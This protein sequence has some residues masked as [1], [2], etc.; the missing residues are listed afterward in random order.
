MKD[1]FL[2][3]SLCLIGIGILFMTSCHKCEKFVK[4]QPVEIG[5]EGVEVDLARIA[6]A[7]PV[8]PSIKVDKV[9]VETEEASKEL[10]DLDLLQYGTCEAIHNIK[11]P[12]LL[13]KKNAEY[14][15]ILTRMVT[16]AQNP[17]R[18]R[19]GCGP[20]DYR[21]PSLAISCSIN[22]KGPDY[23]ILKNNTENEIDLKGYWIIELYDYNF[24][25]FKEGTTIEPKKTKRVYFVSKEKPEWE[26]M[27]KKLRSENYLVEDRW[28][29]RG[30]E[31]IE[32]R[33]ADGEVLDR[34]QAK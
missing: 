30:G 23:V 32:L 24:F 28:S 6:K 26:E 10:Q 11:D 9:R 17:D 29:F 14:A 3:A 12:E 27:A 16:V 5:M 21:G 8:A 4:Y 2:L 7:L 25:E 1:R 20:P 22:S 31:C 18:Y 15:D 13:D 33:N 34:M 19:G